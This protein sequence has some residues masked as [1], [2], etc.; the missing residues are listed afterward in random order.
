MFVGQYDH[1]LDSKNRVV[2]PAPFRAYV[3]DRGYATR[4]GSCIGLWNDEGFTAVA[5][6][7]RQMRTDSEMSAATFRVLMNNV[8]NV[9]LDG[10]GRI[11]LPASLLEGFENGAQVKVCGLYDRVEIWPVHAYLEEVSGQAATPEDLGRAVDDL[12]I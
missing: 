10:A 1:S 6:R 4:L 3:S 8:E 5:R 11:T 7:W 2:L 12:G 9:K